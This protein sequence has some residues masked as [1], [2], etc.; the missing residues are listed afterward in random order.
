MAAGGL[1]SALDVLR[2]ASA[3][4]SAPYAYVHGLALHAPRT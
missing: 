4:L 3:Q 2:A 1:S